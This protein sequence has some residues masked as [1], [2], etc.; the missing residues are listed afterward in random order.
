MTIEG[1]IV[2]IFV[3]WCCVNHGPSTVD[4][5]YDF[6]GS[7]NEIPTKRGCN[8]V[9]PETEQVTQSMLNLS[10]YWLIVLLSRVRLASSLIYHKSTVDNTMISAPA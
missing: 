1:V 4:A 3:R 5:S 7:A 2:V 8:G 6:R 10:S 9:Q